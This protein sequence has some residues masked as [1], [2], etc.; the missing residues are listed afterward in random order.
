MKRQCWIVMGPAASGKS[1]LG[2]R[3]AERLGWRFLEGDD[4]HPTENREKMLRGVPLTDEDRRPWLDALAAAIAA[5]HAAASD[6]VVACSALKRSYRDRLRVA[7]ATRF[8]LL[9]LPRE[10][11]AA[12]LRERPVTTLRP[13]L[14]ESQLATLERP[15]DDE[16]DVEVIDGDRPVEEVVE[17]VRHR[18]E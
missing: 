18:R 3:L 7:G 4:H 5:C 13:D 14:L 6:V 10:V 16:R 11:L 17:A 2:R 12:R 1:T 9:D 8:I 15:Q